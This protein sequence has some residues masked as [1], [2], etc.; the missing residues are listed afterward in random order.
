[1]LSLIRIRVSLNINLSHQITY[2][3]SNVKAQSI[4]YMC[5]C[6]FE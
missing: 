1:M 5:I 3:Y 4:A 6:N 2:Y